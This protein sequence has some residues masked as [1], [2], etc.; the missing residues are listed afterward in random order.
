M[1]HSNLVLVSTAALLVSAGVMAGRVSDQWSPR[2]LPPPERSRNWLVD[3]LK[4][5]S[6]QRQKMDG[7]WSDTHKQ[8]E[9]AFD[10]RRELV[11]HREQAVL[12]LLTDSQRAAYEKIN[13]DFHAQN[14]ELFKQREALMQSANDQSRA[15]LDPDQQ[16][17]WDMLTK[18]MKDRHGPQG[19]GPGW[20]MP[21]G[22]MHGPGDHSPGDHGPGDHGGGMS[23]NDSTT[24]R[25]TGGAEDDSRW[26]G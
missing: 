24:T 12:N 1:L 17:K 25:P 26:H 8:I 21:G 19:G 14:D 3:Q 16:K 4:L 22:R 18:E 15:L 10:H 9:Q 6:D 7:I 5:S 23:H 20:G 11:K 13:T 2:Q